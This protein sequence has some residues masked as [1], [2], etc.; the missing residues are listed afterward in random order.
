MW[1]PGRRSV[2]IGPFT[3][4]AVLEALRPGA[5]ANAPI[6]VMGGFT[7]PLPEGFP[8]W[9][10][11]MDYNVQADRVAARVAFE[12]LNPLVVPVEIT[13]QT[14]LRESDLPALRA[15]GGSRA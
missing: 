5:F 8:A 9:G 11:E 12:R 10:P 2:A 15:G 6:V 13:M 14:A 7:R 4:L 1:K 3:N